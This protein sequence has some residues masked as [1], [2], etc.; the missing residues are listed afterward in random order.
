MSRRWEI[1]LYPGNKIGTE[2]SNHI[3]KFYLRLSCRYETSQIPSYRNNKTPICTV[4]GT[5]M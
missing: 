2:K 4:S 5:A 3:P 1:E